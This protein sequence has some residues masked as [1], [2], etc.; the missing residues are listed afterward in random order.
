VAII[1]DDKDAAE[2]LGEETASFVSSGR[3]NGLGGFLGG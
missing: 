2:A 3:L 1:R